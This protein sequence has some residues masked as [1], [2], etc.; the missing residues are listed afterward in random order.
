MGLR[1]WRRHRRFGTAERCEE[2]SQGYAFFAYPWDGNAPGVAPRQGCEK[3]STPFQGAHSSVDVFQGYAK[4]AYPW[5][6]SLH[7][8]AVTSR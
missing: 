5:L 7:R 6:I 4:N 1:R 2:I 3:S 8:S